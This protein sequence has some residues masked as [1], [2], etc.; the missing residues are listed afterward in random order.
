[1][2]SIIFIIKLINENILIIELVPN[3][4]LAWVSA[5]GSFLFGFSLMLK[6]SKR[7]I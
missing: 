6:K 3:K 4:F 1:L 2:F 7:E 5:I